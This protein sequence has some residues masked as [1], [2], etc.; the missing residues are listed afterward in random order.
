MTVRVP[1][2][3]MVRLNDKV[4]VDGLATVNELRQSNKAGVLFSGVGAIS[5]QTAE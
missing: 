2:G 3:S 1:L 4:P 5:V